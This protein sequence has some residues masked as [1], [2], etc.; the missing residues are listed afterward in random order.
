MKETQEILIKMG[1]KNPNDN[2]W[3][4]DW[5]GVF[6]L[7]NT[8]TPQDLAKFIY[9]RGLSVPQPSTKEPDNDKE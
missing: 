4:S 9:N 6:I 3:Q 5:F 8:A 2:V 7:I 1:F